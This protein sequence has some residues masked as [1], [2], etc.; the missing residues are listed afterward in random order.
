MLLIF[1]N[2]GS[3]MD[4]KKK[5]D[6]PASERWDVLGYFQWEKLLS[7]CKMDIIVQSVT[8][9][10]DNE[11]FN[12]SAYVKLERQRHLKISDNYMQLEMQRCES[13]NTQILVIIWTHQS[14]TY[15]GIRPFFSWRILCTHKTLA[16]CHQKSPKTKKKMFVWG[17]VLYPENDVLGLKPSACFLLTF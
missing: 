7:L 17:T 2:W 8:S 16:C 5:P 3:V 11:A 1:E 9:L 6:R 10:L 12:L 4:E 15:V 14:I 13:I